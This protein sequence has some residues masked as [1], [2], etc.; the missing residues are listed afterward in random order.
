MPIKNG[1]YFHWRV[2]DSFPPQ[3]AY[4]THGYT[5]TDYSEDLHSQAFYE[6][7]II[8]R[9]DGVHYFGDKTYPA[10][11]GDVFIIPPNI[12]H[13]YEGGSGF[14]VFHLLLSPTFMQ[15]NSASLERL[16]AY[17]TLFHIDPLMRERVSDDLHLRLNERLEEIYPF[18]E[19][20]ELIDN[21]P[22]V[23]NCILSDSL[24][25]IVITKLC[26]FYSESHRF[27]PDG[28]VPDN[29]VKS[30]SY[31]YEHYNEHIELD[32]LVRMSNMSRTAFITRF[33]KVTGSSPIRFQ[34]IRRVEIAK[35][36]LA[37]KNMT[38]S[39]IATEVGCY[40]TS[41]FVRLFHQLTGMSPSE[42]RENKG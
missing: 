5:N 31:I 22:T 40:D 9:G 8:T 1:K 13:G 32:E 38:I 33:K 26:A 6:L 42:Y 4:I 19:Q 7:N 17:S 23:A 37:D 39:S 35:Q 10:V 21:N 2:M 24:A 41:H 30:L 14:D 16:S 29:F 11:K 18:L 28:K 34:A 15:K 3:E 25:T 27:E 20:M 36:M 12:L